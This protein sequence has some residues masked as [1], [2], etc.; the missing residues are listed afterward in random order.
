MQEISVTELK[1]KSEAGEKLYI[2]DVREP[3]EYAE[4]NMGGQLVPLGKIL[5][6]QADELEDLKDEELIVHCKAGS[7][8]MQACFVLDQ[9][10]FT[11]T[12]NLTGGILAWRSLYGDAKP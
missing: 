11:N 2:I 8:S 4:F 6:M 3:D 10:G 12:R 5:S 9:I 1:A 7:R